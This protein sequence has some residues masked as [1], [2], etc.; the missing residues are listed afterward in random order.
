LYGT[1]EDT[2]R[3]FTP[4]SGPDTWKLVHALRS[5]FVYTY[6]VI[7]YIGGPDIGDLI[8]LLSEVLQV[9]G[10]YPL[11][12]VARS[13]HP[14]ALLGAVLFNSD[15]EKTITMLLY[16]IRMVTNVTGIIYK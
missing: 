5:L 6:A 12:E 1:D 13:G 14:M 10:S 8:V 4:S 2:K 9:I 15:D 3:I 16:L 11:P 7:N